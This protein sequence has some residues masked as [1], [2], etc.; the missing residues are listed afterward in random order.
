MIANA[1]I[2]IVSISDNYTIRIDSRTLA[3]VKNTFW[4][5]TEI[6]HH[7]IVEISMKI[8]RGGFGLPCN[9]VGGIY[10]DCNAALT[11]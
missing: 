10:I 6:M 8:F 7:T 1:Q 4:N 5:H 11:A 3:L 9:L 2:D